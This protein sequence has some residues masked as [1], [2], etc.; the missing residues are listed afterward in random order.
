MEPLGRRKVQWNT[1]HGAIAD[2]LTV[3]ATNLRFAIGFDA[4]NV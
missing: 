2:G 1:G 4:A 3:N